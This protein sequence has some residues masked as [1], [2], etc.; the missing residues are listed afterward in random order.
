MEF[1]ILSRSL[2]RPL[3][4]CHR[5]ECKMEDLWESVITSLMDL[6]HAETSYMVDFEI[7]RHQNISPFLTVYASKNNLVN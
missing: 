6:Q 1:L 3:I 5:E 4:Q 2:K 7:A